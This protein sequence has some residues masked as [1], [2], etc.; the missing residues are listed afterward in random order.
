MDIFQCLFQN[1]HKALA[2]FKPQTRYVKI[3]FFFFLSWV[4]KIPNDKRLTF[5][6]S[7]VNAEF[8]LWILGFFVSCSGF[9]YYLQVG[10][11]LYVTHG[12][13]RLETGAWSSDTIHPCCHSLLIKIILFIYVIIARFPTPEYIWSEKCS[14]PSFVAADQGIYSLGPL[15]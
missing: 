9:I 11:G 12:C 15:Q 2:F 4:L 3:V 8:S 10:R 1:K 5:R 7:G 14:D 13:G 6:N